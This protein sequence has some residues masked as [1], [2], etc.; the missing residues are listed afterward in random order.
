MWD[1]SSM[2]KGQTRVPHIARQAVNHWTTRGVPQ[3]YILLD[4]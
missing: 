1:L 4:Y 2:T 3:E